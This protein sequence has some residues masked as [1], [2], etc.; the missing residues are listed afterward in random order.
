MEICFYLLGLGAEWLLKKID[1][2]L[3]I[4][5]TIFG[6]L[7]DLNNQKKI[8]NG[9]IYQYNLQIE[10]LEN[11]SQNLN[12]N[13]KHQKAKIISIVHKEQHKIS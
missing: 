8:I 11:L 3:K 9:A 6:E 5:Q 10:N 2:K 13:L 1:K 4:F 7:N 12:K